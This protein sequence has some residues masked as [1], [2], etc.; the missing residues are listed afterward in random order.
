M[1]A[2]T[3]GNNYYG[4]TILSELLSIQDVVERIAPIDFP[5]PS[6]GPG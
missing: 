2:V 4:G 6:P 1:I 5:E 3:P